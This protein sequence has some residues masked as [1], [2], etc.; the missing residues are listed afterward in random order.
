[1]FYKRLALAFYLV[2]ILVMISSCGRS[3]SPKTELQ[4]TDKAVV[5]VKISG[6]TCT[7]CE[8]KIQAGIGKISGIESVKA[9]YVTGN[10]IVEYYPGKA[11]TSEI[12]QA[13]K[14]AGY[15]VKSIDPSPSTDSR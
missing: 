6:M 7:G 12:R 3:K 15:L 10:A 5:E 1:M 14:D 13:V 11:D 9:S 4:N 2:I 8:Q